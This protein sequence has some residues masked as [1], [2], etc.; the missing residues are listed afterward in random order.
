LVPAALTAEGVCLDHFLDA[1]FVRADDALARCHRGEA[2]DAG[3]LEWLLA[4]AHV[5][6]KALADSAARNDLAQQSRIL[7]LILCVANLNE[8]L[9]HHSVKTAESTVDD[10]TRELSRER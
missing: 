10:P 2:I 5:T 9:A 6:L 8:Y 3:T 4:D 7:E 1:S